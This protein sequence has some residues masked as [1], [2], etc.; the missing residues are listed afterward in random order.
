MWKLPTNL[1]LEIITRS[2]HRTL[3]RCAATCNL[4]RCEILT[5]SFHPRVT[6][7]APYI[8]AYLCNDAKKPL[9][10]VHPATPVALSFKVATLLCNY[11]P[12]ACR[13]GLVI[14]CRLNVENR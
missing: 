12:V 14:L 10:P 9:A 8:L 5:P 3:V 11:K 1:L 2:N 13:R 7:A 6:Q 4:F